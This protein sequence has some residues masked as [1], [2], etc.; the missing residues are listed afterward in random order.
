MT[1]QQRAY[2]FALVIDPAIGDEAVAAMVEKFKSLIA[3]NGEITGVDEWGKRRLAYPINYKTEGYYV[4]YNFTTSDH[5]VPAELSRVAKITD[6]VLRW[7]A[8]AK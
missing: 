2:E 6:G 4:F 8:I 3:A 5:G 1:E 7:L